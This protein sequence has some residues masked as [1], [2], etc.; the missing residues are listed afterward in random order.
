MIR[1]VIQRVKKRQAKCRVSSVYI[2]RV[3]QKS[4][5]HE[6]YD[7]LEANF[8]HRIPYLSVEY[9]PIKSSR[10]YQIRRNDYSVSNTLFMDDEL[11]SVRLRT[12]ALRPY[13]IYLEYI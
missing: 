1:Y 12:G 11:G 4:D 5:L 13:G 3:L 2:L 7:L 6:L 9:P 8:T 10:H